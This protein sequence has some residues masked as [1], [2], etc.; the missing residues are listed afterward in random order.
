MYSYI[1]E[2]VTGN[3]PEEVVKLLGAILPKWGDNVIAVLFY[4]SCLRTGVFVN[5]VADF[6]LIVDKLGNHKNTFITFL[7][8]LLPPN[9]YY[10]ETP[11]NDNI[12]RAKYGI[13]TFDQFKKMAS[14]DAFHPYLWARLVQPMRIVYLKDENMK[15]EI[16]K[17]IYTSIMTLMVN[18]A[19][20]LRNPFDLQELWLKSLKL[21]YKTEIRPEG[22]SNIFNIY[23]SNREYLNEIAKNMLEILP[24][25]I[26]VG[27]K[28][29][30]NTYYILVGNW[31]KCVNTIS[32]ALKVVI[33]KLLSATRL[34]KSLFTFENALEYGYYKLSKHTPDVAIPSFFKK[35]LFFS[36]LYLFIVGI[37]RKIF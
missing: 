35:N 37:K 29:E 31:A 23:N 26:Q 22:K 15:I 24:Y 2:K 5:N 20:Q 18:V 1:T 33:G 10:V 30:H 36:C 21:T 13:Y 19:P 9:V 28:G 17:S 12:L 14:M 34:I 16:V 6:Y 25:P 32:W 4:G 7:N 8:K 3:I 27:E 11:Y